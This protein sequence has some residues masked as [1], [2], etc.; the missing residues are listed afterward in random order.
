[1]NEDKKKVEVKENN[2]KFDKKRPRNNNRP[3]K[4]KSD[5]EDKVIEIKRVTKV[6]KGGRQFRF[7]ATVVVG[8]RKGLVLELVRL[9]KCQMQLKRLHKL[10]VKI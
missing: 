3:N 6:V 7:A 2:R 9:K 5:L 1:M 10:Q 4:P 8:N